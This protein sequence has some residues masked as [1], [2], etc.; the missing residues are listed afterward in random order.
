[1]YKSIPVRSNCLFCYTAR[2]YETGQASE[3]NSG[4][5]EDLLRMDAQL[6]DCLILIS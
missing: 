6:G 1:M 3:K 5:E 2:H 4:F